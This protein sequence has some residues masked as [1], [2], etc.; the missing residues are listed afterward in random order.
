MMMIINKKRISLCITFSQSS[1]RDAICLR[2][3]CDN[4][5]TLFIPHTADL[6]PVELEL[7]LYVNEDEFVFKY[8]ILNACSIG[9]AIHKPT[10]FLA[11]FETNK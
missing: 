8:S 4:T 1:R 6:T 5:H 3:N 7:L 10:I 2:L 9:S 11:V